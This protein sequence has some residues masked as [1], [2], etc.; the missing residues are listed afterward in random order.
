MELPPRITSKFVV[1]SQT[2]CWEWVAARD[3]YGY[4]KV[5]DLEAG[6]TAFAHRYV[7]RLLRSDPGVLSLDHLCRNPP[8]VNPDHL[9]PVEH[10][11][12][13]RRGIGADATRAY[14]A[15][16]L[17]CPKGHP[18]VGENLY[19]YR[20][21]TGYINKQCRICRRDTKRARRAAGKRD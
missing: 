3:Q 21:R 11:E 15:A 6:K 8:C 18:L 17:H 1:N 7:Y 10:I 4:G 5:R 16:H 20:H 9:E 12:N 14:Y 2:R 13:V 19:A